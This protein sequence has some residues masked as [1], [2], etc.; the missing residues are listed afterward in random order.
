MIEF[1]RVARLN[2]ANK[3][4]LIKDPEGLRL[5]YEMWKQAIPI[6]VTGAEVLELFDELERKQSHIQDMFD[7]LHALA[8]NRKFVSAEDQQRWRDGEITILELVQIGR[9]SLS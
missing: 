5:P 6:G 4:G 7:E 1:E 8:D 3:M 9:E 2:A